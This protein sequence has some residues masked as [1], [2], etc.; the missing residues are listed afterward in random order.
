MA[1]KWIGSL[2][3]IFLLLLPSSKLFSDIGIKSGL[4][5]SYAGKAGILFSPS[6]L[7]GPKTGFFYVF[8][9]G[10]FFS[11]QPE[12]NYVRKGNKFYC[13]FCDGIRVA[14]LEY[15]EIPVV[16]NVHLLNKTFCHS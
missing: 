3:L 5:L 9:I 6:E 13:A 2:G 16:L 7:Y 4:S 1:K 14:N 11:I 12:L 8:Q 15:L 10:D